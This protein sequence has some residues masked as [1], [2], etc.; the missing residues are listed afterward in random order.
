[1]IVQSLAVLV[2]SILL[3]QYLDALPLIPR[4]EHATFDFFSFAN[5]HDAYLV[6]LGIFVSGCALYEHFACLSALL[7]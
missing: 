4:H 7:D 5:Q 6:I 1:M 3:L 2:S